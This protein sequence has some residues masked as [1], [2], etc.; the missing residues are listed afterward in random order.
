MNAA[1]AQI[2]NTLGHQRGCGFESDSKAVVPNGNGK[3]ITALAAGLA[4]AN[5]VYESIVM[6]SCW[7]RVLALW[8]I[9]KCLVMSIECCGALR[10][11]RAGFDTIIEAVTGEG[12]FLGRIKQ[13]QAWSGTITTRRCR[14]ESSLLGKSRVDA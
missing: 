7:V 3:G 1:A 5:S 12:H 11:R 9:M 10:Q 8:L 4:G 13:W 14:I 6:A 2:S